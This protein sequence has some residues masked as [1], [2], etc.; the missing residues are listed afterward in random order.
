MHI[1]IHFHYI[2][3]G[4]SLS[5][6]NAITLS[7]AVPSHEIDIVDIELLYQSPL[8][9]ISRSLIASLTKLWKPLLSKFYEDSRRSSSKIDRITGN[10][11]LNDEKTLRNIQFGSDNDR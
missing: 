8:G 9:T 7:L 3:G 1:Q 5:Q 4:F 11:F 10:L 6:T 2:T